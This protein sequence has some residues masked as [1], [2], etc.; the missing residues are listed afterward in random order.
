MTKK[1]HV[2][3]LARGNALDWAVIGLFSLLITGVY[4]STKLIS[5]YAGRAI[6]GA[7]VYWFAT[8]LISFSIIP[9]IL[10]I[11]VY[12]TWI[13]P[14]QRKMKPSRFCQLAL[15]TLGTVLYLVPG[16]ILIIARMKMT[17]FPESA[18]SEEGEMEVK[19]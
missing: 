2:E 17:Q 19:I 14:L 7:S 4:L 8:G 10:A 12:F 18:A 11:L 5:T 13:R 6:T 1:E 15:I 16:F 9:L 3:K